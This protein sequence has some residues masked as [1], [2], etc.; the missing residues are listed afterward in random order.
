MYKS[1]H[2]FYQFDFRLNSSFFNRGVSFSSGVPFPADV[3][4]FFGKLFVEVSLGNKFIIKIKYLKI[5]CK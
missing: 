4:D 2:N 5:L 1:C 3:S